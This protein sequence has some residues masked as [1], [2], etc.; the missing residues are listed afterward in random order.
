MLFFGESAPQRLEAT[1]SHKEDLSES[2]R[3]RVFVATYFL[4]LGVFSERAGMKV[5]PIGTSCPDRAAVEAIAS[6]PLVKPLWL[7]ILGTLFSRSIGLA[8][9]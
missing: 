2:L 5:R 9:Q 8:K 6:R 7:V 1:K 3:L 4:P